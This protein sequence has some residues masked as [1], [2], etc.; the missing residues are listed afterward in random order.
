ME[1]RHILTPNDIAL[2]QLPTV[3]PIRYDDYVG[4]G[5]YAGLH[6]ALKIGPT[7]ILEMV[8]RSGLRGRGGAGFP[9]WKKWDMVIQRNS[10][11][12][13]LCCN[14]AE[15]EPGTFKDRYLLRSNPHQ[16]IEGAIIS[17]YAVG[18]TEAYIYI[19]G[20]YKEELQFME[21]ALQEARSHRHWGVPFPG[22]EGGVELKM[23]KSP[24][25]YVAGE[26]TA[27][28]EVIEGRVA[29]PRQKPPY[30]PAAHGLYGMPTVVNNAETLSDI[31]HIVRL[32]ADWF[33]SIGTG[34]SPGTMVFT[35]TGDID[36]PGLYELPL[37]LPLRELIE[38]YGGGVRG[39][40]RLKAVFPGGPSNTIIRGDQ[41]DVPLDFDALKG[42]GS[43]LGTGA[44]IVMSEDVCMVRAAIEY[45]RFFARESCGQCPPCKLGTEHIS[46]ILEKIESGK[47]TEKDVQLVE[48]V[49]KMVK[50]RGYCYLLTGASIA[51]ESIFNHFKSEFDA[52]VLEAKCP[53]G[54]L[55][56]L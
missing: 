50:G 24:G 7:E 20:H 1:N 28:L 44:V 47:G 34:S 56:A 4:R 31:P 52:H 3:R 41:I 33:R 35:L 27:L 25:T 43:G 8:R 11:R 53:F 12:K 10:T 39:G 6:K 36:R 37:G 26:E 54:S 49:C 9:T 46:Q 51:V 38:V 17:A 55:A 48:Q 22:L 14:A 13:Y 15:D 23:T 21:R 45:A 5:G 42:I 29:A 2:D 40:R 32:G 16:L 18:A 30:Y 19:N